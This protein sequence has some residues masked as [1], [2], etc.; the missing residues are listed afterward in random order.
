MKTI[1]A[2]ANGTKKWYLVDASNKIAG[3]LSSEIASILKGKKN[4]IF[5]P[6]LDTGDYIVIINASKI[7]F[8]G[9]KIN[10]KVYYRHTGYP[11]G[12]KKTNLKDAMNNKPSW[13]LQRIIAGMMPRGILGRDMLKKL[14]IYDDATHKQQAQQPVLLEI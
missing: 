4:P 2:S 11:G 9:N 6:N 8:S 10:N 1:T 3:R 12:I 7:K 5:T 13:V 14:F